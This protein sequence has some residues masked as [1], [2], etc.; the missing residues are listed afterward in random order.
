M[1]SAAALVALAA[2]W[3]LLL[4]PAV[5]GGPATY[6][7]VSGSSMEPGLHTGDL[8]IARKQDSY[9]VGDVIVYHVREGAGPGAFV[10]HRVVGGSAVNGF[11]TR[12]DNRKTRDFWRPRPTEIAGKMWFPVPRAGLALGFLRTTPGMAALA[13][14]LTFFLVALPSKPKRGAS[15][16]RSEHEGGVEPLPASPPDARGPTSGKS[17]YRDWGAVSVLAIFLLARAARRYPAA[18]RRPLLPAD[19]LSP[20]PVAQRIERQTSNLRA[21]VRLLPGPLQARCSQSGAPPA[22]IEVGPVAS[23]ATRAARGQRGR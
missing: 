1:T 13:A 3:A 19:T 9:G 16:R 4:R 6:V 12:G 15:E 17:P 21:E 22:R 8:V 2:A 5:L 14:L 20:G 10:I 18:G 23:A 7:M 11:V